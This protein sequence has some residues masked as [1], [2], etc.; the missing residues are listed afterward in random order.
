MLQ[1][2]LKSIVIFQDLDDASLKGIEHFIR[3]KVYK[4][5]DCIVSHSST[6]PPVVMALCSGQVRVI[7]F[8]PQ[9]KEMVI[10]DVKVGE[11]FGDWSAIDNQPRS[12]SVY[13][14][15]D[16][17]VG[18]M[19]Q[20]DFLT[21]VTHNPRIA[22]RQMEQLTIQLRGMTRRLTEF[23]CL[24]A[25]LRIQGVLVEL[26]VAGP[27]GLF[28]QKIANHQEIASRAYTQREVVVRELSSLQ[29]KGLLVKF[30]DGFLI[31][32]PEELDIMKIA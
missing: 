10:R 1:E 6:L 18:V 4:A 16:S 27:E 14:V 21:L 24:R 9:G 8:N 17:A 30:N 3:T 15:K 22:F 2:H 11:L 28:I 20:Q 31:P 12:A 25:N 5:G 19:S 7:L 26:A 32:R 29:A 23:A 13:A